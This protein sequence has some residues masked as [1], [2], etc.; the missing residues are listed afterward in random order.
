MVEK[1]LKKLP[2]NK[3]QPLAEQY[4]NMNNNDI[5]TCDTGISLSKLLFL[6]LYFVTRR[7]SQYI[8]LPVV[9]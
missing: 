7:Y 6:K 8:F 5:N 9:L 2:L 4:E 1:K 3:K